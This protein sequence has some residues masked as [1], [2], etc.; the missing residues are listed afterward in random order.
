M[1]AAAPPQLNAFDLP[2]FLKRIF[3]GQHITLLF[4]QVPDVNYFAKDAAGRFVQADAGF[5]AMLGAARLEDVLGKT[6]A[7]FFPPEYTARFVADD[8]AVMVTGQPLCQQA[9]PVPR[10]DRTFEWRVVT[11]VPL[12]DV[13]GQIIGIAGITCRIHAE[14]ATCHP[15]IYAILEHIGVNYGKRITM[16]NLAEIATLSPST[17]ERHFDHMFQTS[18]LRYLNTVRLRAARHL[19]LTTDDSLSEIAIACG[20]SDQ[21]HMTAQFRRF[22]G[23]TP[24][25]YRLAQEL[26]N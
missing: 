7:D 6:D 14:N 19:L 20:F 18:P 21:S 22:F 16:R 10:P 26:P 5:V 1:S 3:G 11:K 4:S 25:R 13:D 9:E 12:R 24:R 15:G 2:V 8:Q 17:I 23:T